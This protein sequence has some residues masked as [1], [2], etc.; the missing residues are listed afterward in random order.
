MV[1]KFIL[2]SIAALMMSMTF[3]ATLSLF[4]GASTM[5]IA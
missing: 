5:A 3:G 4:A 2:A 1:R